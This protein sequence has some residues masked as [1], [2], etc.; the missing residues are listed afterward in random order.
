MK[1]YIEAGAN[2]GI[3]QSRSLNL[4]NNNEYF[5]ILIEP[6]PDMYNQCCYNRSK[7]SKIYNCALVDFEHKEPTV[8]IYIHNMFSAMA[9]IKKAA[10]EK[11]VNKIKVPARTLDSILEEL[12]VTN[13]DYFYL[14]VEGY[15]YNV[16][17]GINFNKRFFNYIEIEC[18]F[19]LTGIPMDEEITMHNN[20]LSFYGYK[21]TDQNMS[22]GNLKLIFTYDNK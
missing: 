10:S 9:T 5:G 3:F 17:K 2:D 8:D 21:M 15:E 6:L 13:I 4:V 20:L 18:H 1:F 14:D 7:N 19:T 16:L 22:D 12:D 11:Y